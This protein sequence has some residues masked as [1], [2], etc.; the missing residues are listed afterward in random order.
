MFLQV[1][2]GD[3]LYRDFEFTFLGHVK[4]KKGWECKKLARLIALFVLQVT[5]SESFDL[6]S[7][8]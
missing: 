2:S 4:I 8:H 7:H 5:K 1:L 6:L 3:E